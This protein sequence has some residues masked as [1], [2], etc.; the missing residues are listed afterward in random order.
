ML[1]MMHKI[2]SNQLPFPLWEQFNILYASDAMCKMK[3]TLQWT[4][5]KTK[6]RRC[7]DRQDDREDCV[8][9]A[10]RIKQAKKLEEEYHES[11]IF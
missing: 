7:N 8:G 1:A 10:V 11:A 6:E 4:R 3:I 9:G 2:I 5:K